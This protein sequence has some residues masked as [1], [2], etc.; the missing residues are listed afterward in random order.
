MTLRRSLV[1]TL[2][3]LA[4][5]IPATPSLAYEEDTHFLMTYII[6]RT[7]GFTHQEALT[8][9]AVDQGMDDSPGTVANGGIGGIVPNVREEWLWHAL[10]NGGQ[11]G[12]KGILKRKEELF[13]LAA[14]Q[15]TP[16]DKL[17]YLG[18]FFRYQQDTWAHRHHYDGNPQSL[19]AYTT[20]DTPFG[21]A[22]HGHQ[23]DRPPFDPGTAFQSLEDGM[24][25]AR[26]FLKDVLKREP[27][28]FF[29]DYGSRGF[30]GI[31]EDGDWSDDRKG[32]YFHM[33]GS[34]GAKPAQAF[35]CK[36]IQAQISSYTS[37]RDA[38][39]EFFLRDTADEVNFDTVRT[40]L[41][42]VCDNEKMLGMK[43]TLP[44]KQDKLNQGFTTL[45]T[46]RLAIATSG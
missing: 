40:A 7:T 20:Y 33:L 8:V 46:A 36:L 10:D 37:S 41:Q 25:M 45:T 16:Q 39:P 28:A 34:R 5:L 1:L 19:D 14:R 4:L 24:N 29:A 23:P 2:A 42:Q 35:L 31:F 44:T 11:M 9:A 22:R 32:K 18:V 21:H 38:N 12:P 3:A 6:C 17:L 27:T 43:L 30:G 15:S 26:G 13:Q